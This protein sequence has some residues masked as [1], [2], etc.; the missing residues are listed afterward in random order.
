MADKYDSSEVRRAIAYKISGHRTHDIKKFGRVGNID[1]PF[2]SNMISQQSG[3]CAL[4]SEPMILSG[5]LPYCV[6]QFTIDRILDS[7]PHMKSNVVISCYHCNCSF[8]KNFSRKGRTCMRDCHYK[9]R[10][11]NR[12]KKMKIHRGPV[13]GRTRSNRL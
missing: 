1:V 9:K 13:S 3:K 6:Y 8:H 5:W 11:V 2:I 7:L 12:W 10:V 4:C